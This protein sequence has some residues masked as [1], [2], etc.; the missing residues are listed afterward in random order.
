MIVS[1]LRLSVVLPLIVA[2][3]L[4]LVGC[5]ATTAQN[6]APT[7]TPMVPT[8]RP[9]T[10]ARPV[11]VPGAVGFPQGPVQVNPPAALPQTLPAPV[12][13]PPPA[14]SVPP[15]TAPPARSY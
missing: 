15:L 14:P 5:D 6:P 1:P 8:T 3:P 9:A 13:T 2:A 7:P 4:V 12:A 11:G 10:G